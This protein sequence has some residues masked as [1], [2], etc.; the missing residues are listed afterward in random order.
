MLLTNKLHDIPS[1][2]PNGK[3]SNGRPLSPANVRL[4]IL[5]LMVGSLDGLS[6][7]CCV[8]EK[9]TGLA[10]G[11]SLGLDVGCLLGVEVGCSVGEEVTGLPVGFFE[12]VS[13]GDP[14]GCVLGL[15]VGFFEGVSVGNPVGSLLGL[16]DGGFGGGA[17][18]SLPLSSAPS[19]PGIGSDPLRS[20]HN[21]SPMQSVSASQSPTVPIVEVVTHDRELDGYA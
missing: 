4:L 20:Q 1:H 13:V 19:Q 16:D 15:D 7:G 2:S 9:V 11:C 8:G 10:V 12:G 5:G 6:V 18:K 17:Q 3:A 14:V 21:K